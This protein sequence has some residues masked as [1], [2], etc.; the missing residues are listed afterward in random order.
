[1]G[2]SQ[3]SFSPTFMS[4]Y[5]GVGKVG[6]PILAE[7]GVAALSEVGVP[8]AR[9]KVF[10]LVGVAALG[11]AALGVAGLAGFLAPRETALVIALLAVEAGFDVLSISIIRGDRGHVPWAE[12]GIYLPGDTVP[13]PFVVLA[14]RSESARSTLSTATALAALL[15]FPLLGDAGL[16]V[17]AASA[18]HAAFAVEGIPF[19]NSV[20]AGAH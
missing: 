14:P 10:F 13:P 9:G 4:V 16:I 12:H 15:M 11:V 8:P 6:G 5:T 18:I 17:F 1:M 2:D 7:D 19:A 3:S 20:A